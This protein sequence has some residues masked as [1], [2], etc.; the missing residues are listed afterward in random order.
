VKTT[1]LA[2]ITD[3]LYHIMFVHLALIKI[4][5]HNISGDRHWLHR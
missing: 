1:N 5:T 2:Q 3:K 4:R